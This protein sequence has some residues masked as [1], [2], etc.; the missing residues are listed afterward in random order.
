MENESEGNVLFEPTRISGMWKIHIE[1][2][3]DERGSF[4]RM[5]CQDT[6]HE[7]GLITEFCQTSISRTVHK[8]TVRGMHM[9][10]SPSE[11]VKLIYCSR[12]GVFD[13]VCDV[14]KSSP[15]YLEKAEIFL[16]EYSNFF[17]YVPEGCLHGYQTLQDHSV[18]HY[19][20]SKNYDPISACGVRYD[21]PFLGIKWPLH[22]SVISE[23]DR[24]FP[25]FG[26]EDFNI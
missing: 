4:G 7:N 20:I 18:I 1:P 24:L 21:D 9:Q 22:V 12:G 5:F 13:V 3:E 2:K 17:L 15:T 8:G 19:S 16:D 25:L 11:E 10:R 26:T 23:K 14:R 6:F